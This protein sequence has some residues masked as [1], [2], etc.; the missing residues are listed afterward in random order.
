MKENYK[1]N[2]PDSELPPDSWFDLTD[3]ERERA[4][5]APPWWKIG[6]L[7][8]EEYQ[9]VLSEDEIILKNLSLI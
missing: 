3:E 4:T 5:C 6:I 1:I 8:P 9:E 2:L 7:P